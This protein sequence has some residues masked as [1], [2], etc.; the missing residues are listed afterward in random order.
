ML[1]G[2]FLGVELKLIKQLV[3][4]EFESLLLVLHHINHCFLVVTEII[5][6]TGF[7]ACLVGGTAF[8]SLL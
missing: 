3:V 5:T 7:V 8:I 2:L 4:S 6:I 1:S